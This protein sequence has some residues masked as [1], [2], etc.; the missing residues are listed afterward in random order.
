MQIDGGFFEVLDYLNR[1]EDLER[2]VL[3]DSI[4]VSSRRRASD[5]AGTTGG[6]PTSTGGAPDLSVTLTGR[7]F[8]DAPPTQP[9][10]DPSSLRRPRRP[11]AHRTTGTTVPGGTT[12][13][14]TPP[15]SSSG[16]S[17]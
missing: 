8:T 15:A 9:R 6:G 2:L 5:G 14:T 16:A 7:M 4:N 13:S 17:S 12:G 11:A 1:L 10:T 3:V